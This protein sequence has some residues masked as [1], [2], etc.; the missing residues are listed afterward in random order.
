MKIGLLPLYIELY[1]KAT[2]G[3]RPR[4]EGFYNEIKKEFE[5]RGV[6]VTTSDFCRLKPEFDKTIKEFEKAEVDAIVTLHMAY[7]PSLESIEA[8]AKTDLAVVVLDTTDTLEFT[9]MQDPGDVSYCHGV[10]GVMDMCSMLTRYD[11][12]YAIAAGHYKESD[13]IDRCVGFVKSAMAA[14]CIKNANVALIGGAFEGMG[15]FSVSAAELKDTFGITINDADPNELLKISESITD[16]EIKKEMEENAKRFPISENTVEEDYK[17]SVRAC[18]SVRRYIEEKK[19]TAFSVNFLKMGGGAGISSMPFVECCKAMERGIG[20]AGEG[21]GLTAAFTGAFMQGYP[22]TNFVEIFCPDWKNN[23]VFL[24][25]MGEVNYRIADTVPTIEPTRGNLTGGSWPY[26]GYTRMM[27][28][29]GVYVNISRGKDDYQLLIAPSEMKSVKEDNFPKHMRGWM[30]PET[31]STAEFLEQLSIHG[32]THHSC[33]IY[34]ATV[35]EMEFFAKLISV[36]S[37]VIK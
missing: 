32:A 22:K 25:H 34:D 18:L 15:D 31:V 33:F 4:L 8:L 28:G 5:E 6:E 26:V 27:G 30:E 17:N 1:D 11:K 2:P 7:S 35:E 23:T 10:H 13:C 20:Y 14:K 21:D 19:L 16:D 37:V 36:R 9:P 3:L 29:K 24:S 12:P